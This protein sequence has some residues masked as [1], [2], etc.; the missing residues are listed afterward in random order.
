MKVFWTAFS[1]FLAIACAACISTSA[2]TGCS[3]AHSAAL[4]AATA[5]NRAG[6]E[7]TA[8]AE[9]G[10]G[11]GWRGAGSA[12][13][14]LPFEVSMTTPSSSLS[15]MASSFDEASIRNLAFQNGWENQLPSILCTNM[16]SSRSDTVMRFNMD[17]IALAASRMPIH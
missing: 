5:R 8:R 1:A 2:E 16:P 13:T 3:E 12:A 6:G 7:D 11:A 15:L 4:R 9:A 14:S 17:Q 10:K